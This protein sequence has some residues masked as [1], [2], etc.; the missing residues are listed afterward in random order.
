MS[1]FEFSPAAS[2]TLN[3]Y[4][5]QSWHIARSTALGGLEIGPPGFPPPG[6]N[7]A[8]G[9]LEQDSCWRPIPTS[10][11]SPTADS[12]SPINHK[13]FIWIIEYLQIC[14]LLAH[15]PP[16]S[17]KV[18]CNRLPLKINDSHELLINTSLQ[19][20]KRAKTR[21][22]MD[23]VLT[24][25]TPVWIVMERLSI[26]SITAVSA[27]AAGWRVGAIPQWGLQ[28]RDKQWHVWGNT[29]SPGLYPTAFGLGCVS[30]RWI[31]F[32]F[33]G[34]RKCHTSFSFLAHF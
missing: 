9:D 17:N 6:G 28:H 23:S 32:I 29:K 34:A 5:S 1:L 24:A 26:G 31:F 13:S 18:P 30:L 22:E 21:Q 7:V 25:D 16:L 33:I 10:A 4:S 14:P 20:K 3:K 12:L 19:A 8:G 15:P 27:V 11:V 2:K